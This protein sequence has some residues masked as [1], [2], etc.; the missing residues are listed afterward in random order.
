VPL[1]ERVEADM[2][3]ARK[4]RDE[5]ALN[6]LGLLKSEV[7]KATKEPGAP[8]GIDDQMVLRVVRK[9]VKRRE[10]AAEVYR[11]AGREEAAARETREAEILRAYLPAALSPEQ[12]EREIRQ[13]IEDVQPAGPGGF[14]MVMKEAS[15]RLA[16][17]AEG[18]EIASV[19]RRL[20]GQG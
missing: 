10:E 12:L 7:V 6:T 15:K 2:I 20:L 13:V 5:L 17:R 9:E 14:G 16:G 8:L 3:D 1:Y 19:A 4:R 18:G 11:G